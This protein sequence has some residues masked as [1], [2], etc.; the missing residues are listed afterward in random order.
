M[1]QNCYLEIVTVIVNC[2]LYGVCTVYGL[3]YIDVIAGLSML[4]PVLLGR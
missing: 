1:K 3:S 2:K 4:R